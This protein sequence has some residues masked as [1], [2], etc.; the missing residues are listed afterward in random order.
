M[1]NIVPGMQPIVQQ[2]QRS[3]RVPRRPRHNFAISQRPYHLQPFMIAPVLPG[4]TLKQL[5]CQARVVSDPVNNPLIGWWNEKYFF[6]VKHRD[7]DAR[8][9]LV[10]MVLNPGQSLASLEEANAASQYYFQGNAV[11]WLKLCLKRITEEYFRMEDEP[12]NDTNAYYD[13]LP[14]ATLNDESWLDSAYLASDTPAEPIVDTGLPDDLDEKRRQWE[15]LHQYGMTQ[16]SYEQW[17][18]TY[19]VR[20]PA[21]DTE[22]HAPELIR[23]S[24]IWSYPSNTINPADGSPSSALS[25]VD[26]FSADKDRYFKEPGWIVGIS[27]VR[28]KVYLGN[29]KG[30]AATMLNDAYSWLPSITTGGQPF[31]S[32]KPF[33]YNR[34]PLASVGSTTASDYWVDVRDLFMH[35]D[36]FTNLMAE[37]NKVSLPNAS[38]QRRFP[39]NADMTALFKTATANKIKQDGV[40]ALNILGAQQDWSPSRR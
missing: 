27:C 39:T 38:L 31:M 4:E 9:L 22:L 1:S 10:D 7:L 28:P 40:V 2:V 17:L 32:L 15:H 20:L 16:M 8:D 24:R 5:R 33:A 14:I 37:V 23:Y 25:W 35:G 30:Y 36:Q 34:G 12:W 29:Q 11:N 19:G 18:E 6:Y 3:Q 13:D 26:E 21:E